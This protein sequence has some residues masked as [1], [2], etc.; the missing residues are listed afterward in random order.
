MSNLVCQARVPG[1]VD[2]NAIVDIMATLTIRRL[3]DPLKARLRVRAA[4]HGRS[5]EEEA[6]Q[7]LKAELQEEPKREE[8]LA[9]SIRRIMA[10]PAVW[11]WHSP[12]VS[13]FDGPQTL[14]TDRPRYER[15]LGQS[16]TVALAN[17]SRL[18]RWSGTS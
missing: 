4:H 2:S 12:G 16:E 6:R 15:V 8:N 10:P 13:R 14:R 5:M 11:S 18:A 1:F 3:D 17:C 7:I 9:E